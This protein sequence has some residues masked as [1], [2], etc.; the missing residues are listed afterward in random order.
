MEEFYMLKDL[1]SK[2]FNPSKTRSRSNSEST[3]IKIHSGLKKEFSINKELRELIYQICKRN[4]LTSSVPSKAIDYIIEEHIKGK[5]AKG[6]AEGLST[7]L[8]GVKQKELEAISRNI[9]SIIS[10]ART[11]SKSQEIGISWYVWQTSQDIRVRDSHKLMQGVI[12]NWKYPPSPEFLNSEKPIGTYHA[13]E[14]EDC[15]CYAEPVIELDYLSW[16]CKVYNSGKITT[17]T[18]AQFMKFAKMN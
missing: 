11:Q 7:I 10:T 8:P 17:M 18:K 15:R 12:V 4:H 14:G 6:M 2:I 16:P 1:F 9:N 3:N 5:R 13:G